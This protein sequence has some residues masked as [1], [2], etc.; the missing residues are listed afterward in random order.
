[1]NYTIGN[2]RLTVT[3]KTLS[4]TFSSIKMNGR[5]Y[6]WQGDPDTWGGQSPICFPICGSLRNETAS[7]LDGKVLH[8]GRHG[9]VRKRDFH[10]G[11]QGKD[12]ASLVFESSEETKEMYPYDFRLTAS[13]KLEGNKILVR[14]DVTNTGDSPLPFCIGG[15]TGY[16]CPLDEGED[17]SDYEVVFEKNEQTDVP[18]PVAATKL[19]DT[20]KRM[21]IPMEGNVLP[22]SHDLFA[23]DL[24]VFDQMQSKLVYLHKKGETKGVRVS[25]D[26]P[27]LVLWS[28]GKPA[29][30]LAIEPWQGNCTCENED[31]VF[32]HKPGVLYAKPG[33]TRGI[34]FTI[35]ILD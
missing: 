16:R 35:E 13:Y 27:F 8:M 3:L 10:F 31:D 2:D 25:F 12:C 26:L 34:G 32:D 7:T 21:P 29:D 5:E 22:L 33:E 4:G 17:Y 19:L 1:M 14:Y 23:N 28:S 6:L 11:E 20:E 9:F 24:L 15:H 18:T 30:F